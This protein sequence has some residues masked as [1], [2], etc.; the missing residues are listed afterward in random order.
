MVTMQAASWLNL[1]EKGEDCFQNVDLIRGFANGSALVLISLMFRDN[2][3]K[4]YL[5]FIPS[6]L[7]PPSRKSTL[8]HS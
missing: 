4:T 2:P 5:D 3:R 8:N 7:D 6:I 1:C